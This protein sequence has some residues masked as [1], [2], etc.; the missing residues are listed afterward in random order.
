MAAE[1]T[2]FTNGSR[3]HAYTT[4]LQMVA[5]VLIILF[6]IIA[7]A[8]VI[9]A[10]NYANFFP[11]TFSGTLITCCGRCAVQGLASDRCGYGSSCCRH[12]QARCVALASCSSP[13]LDS[14]LCRPCRP[15]PPPQ[16]GA[17][18]RALANINTRG[19][20]TSFQWV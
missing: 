6:V 3:M 4:A 16:S 15:A 5:T 8:T 7:G 1:G 18:H 20:P 10:E 13:T 9:Q 12:D 11:Y 19:H 17:P 14:T 2:V